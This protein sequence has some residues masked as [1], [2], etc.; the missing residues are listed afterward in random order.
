M[1]KFSLL[2]LVF[3]L[4]FCMIPTVLF[5]CEKAAKNVNLYY[6]GM[7][8]YETSFDAK[9]Y[10]ETDGTTEIFADSFSAMTSDNMLLSAYAIE[11]LEGYI[12]SIPSVS[13]H[14]SIKITKSQ[15]ITV[16]FKIVPNKLKKPIVIKYNGK[17]IS[18]Q[19]TSKLDIVNAPVVDKPQTGSGEPSNKIPTGNAEIVEWLSKNWYYLVIGFLIL[20]LIIALVEIH[21]RNKNG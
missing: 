6:S 13:Y 8:P 17:T 2:S 12:G 1:K 5:G 7:E 21:K 9:V 16:Y 10:V 11:I 4:M 18:D 19:A 20:L 15:T 14:S 3:A